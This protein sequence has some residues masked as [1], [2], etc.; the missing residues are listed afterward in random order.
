MFP[1]QVVIKSLLLSIGIIIGCTVSAYGQ[2]PGWKIE[3]E[4]KGRRALSPRLEHPARARQ[5]RKR[6][7][8][9]APVTKVTPDKC[10]KEKSKT[11]PKTE[12]TVPLYVGISLVE[13]MVMEDGEGGLTGF[14]IELWEMIATEIGTTHKYVIVEFSE[15]FDRL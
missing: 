6:R 2:E 12:L 7:V 14:D 4:G 9:I 5:D 1:R 3:M 10:C 15:L 8:V 13:P 11:L